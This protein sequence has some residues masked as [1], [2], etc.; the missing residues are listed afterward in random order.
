[1]SSL[2]VLRMRQPT[3]KGKTMTTDAGV[4]AEIT[5]GGETRAWDN[6]LELRLNK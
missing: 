1:M 4:E 2:A 5:N 3:R 6:G